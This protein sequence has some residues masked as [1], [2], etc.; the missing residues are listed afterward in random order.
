MDVLLHEVPQIQ[1]WRTAEIHEAIIKAFGLAQGTNT[2]TQTP[3]RPAKTKSAPTSGTARATLCYR[4]N[5]KEV[6]V[7]L[8]LLLFHRWVC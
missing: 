3:L 2:L 5:D 4:L 7:A 1:G 6:R 8:I